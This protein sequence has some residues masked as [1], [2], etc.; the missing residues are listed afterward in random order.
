MP[1]NAETK[2]I[3]RAT[4]TLLGGVA[5]LQMRVG[6]DED[7]MAL[8]DGGIPPRALQWFLDAFRGDRVSQA[9]ILAA[10]GTART[11]KRRMVARQ[12]LTP[13]E[14]GRLVRIARLVAIASDVLGDEARARNWVSQPNRA[15]G[16]RR[17]LEVARTDAGMRSAENVLGR[18]QHGVFS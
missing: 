6:A 15:L 4:A 14:S 18:I 12:K 1:P 11:L 7:L 2:H 10:V 9:D 13:Q 8:R 17:P 5:V 16:G 3:A